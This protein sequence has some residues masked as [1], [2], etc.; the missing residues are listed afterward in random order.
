MILAAVFLVLGSRAENTR[1][2]VAVLA[3]GAGALYLSQSSFWSV[4]ADIGGRSSGAVSGFMNMGNQIG[5]MITA[6]LTPWIAAR[7]GWQAPFF[8][9]AVLCLGG[10]VGWLFVDPLKRLDS[11]EAYAKSAE[12]ELIKTP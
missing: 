2:A 9:A 11:A 6:S 10:A 4:T 5:G 1:V 7:L 3:G 12:S 8:V